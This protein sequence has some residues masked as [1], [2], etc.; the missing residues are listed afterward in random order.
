MSFVADYQE[1]PKLWEYISGDIYKR[2]WPGSIAV[3][4]WYYI[5]PLALKYGDKFKLAFRDPSTGA[6]TRW[7]PFPHLLWEKKFDAEG[8][9]TGG[10]IAPAVD[11]H[12][13]VLEN[14]I[15]IES[16]Y[17]TYE[18]NFEASKIIG[19]ILENKGFIPHYY[20][21]GN[22]SV[23]I[24]VFI[25][26]EFK[27]NL[28]YDQRT[29]LDRKFKEED[30]FKRAFIEWLRS[31][32]ISCWDTR[33]RK[34]DQDLI[35]AT[36]LI[37]AELSRN[38]QG[39]KTFLGYSHKDMSFVPIVCNELNEIYPKLGEVKTSPA[40]S[41]G[42][43]VDEFLMH[44]EAI[45]RKRKL[46]R[47]TKSLTDYT[48][49]QNEVIRGCVKK[50]M[51]DEFKIAAD[52]SKRGMFILVNELKRILGK[53]QARI[54]VDDWNNRMGN[55]IPERDIDYRFRL[56]NYTLSCAYIHE[57]LKELGIDVSKKCN[58]KVYKA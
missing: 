30:K 15:V 58:G 49:P 46:S 40:T 55:L 35:R 7:L 53:G 10:H 29:V 37:R 51:S 32:M 48:K 1:N 43:L 56:K 18:E 27:R 24:H 8:K 21:S 6:W 22:K 39:F 47:T 44:L 12:R 23:H 9:L 20:Y 19:T 33:I 42:K 54:V 57:F 28:T 11:V 14:E 38:K 50:I 16:D 4:R 34:F 45:A 52:G 5:Q 2:T 26:W 36:H 41:L 3:D 25:D 31:K 13:S 17:P